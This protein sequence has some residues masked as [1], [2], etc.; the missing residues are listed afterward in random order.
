M[1]TTYEDAIAEAF[2]EVCSGIQPFG[3]R[4]LV[5]IRTAKNK[6]AGGILLTTDTTDTEKWNT[7]VAKVVT[8]G[9]LAF[10]NRNTMESWPEGNWCKEGEFVRVAKYGGDRWEVPIPDA[11][12][13]EAAMFVIFNDLDILGSVIGDPLKVKA[14][15]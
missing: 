3:S 13:G 11:T 10:K 1:T 8:V 6:T 2:P 9:P 7:Q 5:Q 14:F 12:N 4:V 15:I